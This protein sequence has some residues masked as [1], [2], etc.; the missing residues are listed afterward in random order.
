MAAELDGVAAIGSEEAAVRYGVPVLARA[1]QDQA[2]NTTRFLLVGQQIGRP[3]GRDKTSILFS[4][5]D[6]VGALHDV[7]SV[8]ARRGINLTRIESRPSRR[9]PWEYVFFVDFTGHPDEQ[10]AAAALAEMQD[11]CTT[12]KVLGAWPVERRVDDERSQAAE[13]SRRGWARRLRVSRGRFRRYVRRAMDAL[14]PQFRPRRTT[15]WWWWSASRPRRTTSPGRGATEREEGTPLYGVYRGIP[16]P[17]RAGGAPPEPAGRDRRL[18]AAPAGGVPHRGASCRRRSGSPCC[19]RWGTTSGW[20]R[21]RSSTSEPWPA[22]P[23]RPP[24]SEYSKGMGSGLRP[25]PRRRLVCSSWSCSSS[26]G[27]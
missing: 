1:I 16:L 6:R 14:P 4:V 8:F 21:R 25:G 2:H 12:V 26:G 3:S 20:R 11:A 27:A 9:Q 19:T 5:R 22:L 13:D 18:P 23:A 17:L 24:G 15:W 7:L 10:T